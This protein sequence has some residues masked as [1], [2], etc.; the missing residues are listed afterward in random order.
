MPCWLDITAL[1][2]KSLQIFA[3]WTSKHKMTVEKELHW[4]SLQTKQCS[5]SWYRYRHC[6]KTVSLEMM[7]LAPMTHRNT[8]NKK[9]Q[10]GSFGIQHKMKTDAIAANSFLGNRRHLW[11]KFA[12]I[13]TPTSQMYWTLNACSYDLWWY[14]GDGKAFYVGILLRSKPSASFHPRPKLPQVPLKVSC[15]RRRQCVDY[16][17]GLNLSM[18]MSKKY[19]RVDSS[20]LMAT[21]MRKTGARRRADMHI[22]N[23]TQCQ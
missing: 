18:R 11:S 13:N 1:H 12:D 15:N 9:S 22:P 17:M 19:V 16:P 20:Q 2:K 3:N 23:S 8:K 6:R 7:L 10:T 21:I 4:G 14:S 5:A